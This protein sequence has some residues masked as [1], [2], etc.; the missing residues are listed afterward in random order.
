VTT[1]PTARGVTLDD[2]TQERPEPLF[3][4]RWTWRAELPDGTALANDD[5][6]SALR[7]PELLLK[8]NDHSTP[9]VRGQ[10][11]PLTTILNTS[12]SSAWLAT[13]RFNWMLSLELLRMLRV[14]GLHAAVLIPPAMSGRL[15]DRELS[16]NLSHDLFLVE[17]L[18]AFGELSD[19]LFG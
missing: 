19:Y 17:Q 7:N 2:L 1:S 15:G 11:L 18:F 16:T 5:A 10:N 8:L 13:V 12:I 4:G 9:T 14:V 6:G 3:V